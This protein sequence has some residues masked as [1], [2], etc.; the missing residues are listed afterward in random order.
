M[1][2]DSNILHYLASM[3][4]FCSD[5]RDEHL[6]EFSQA[7][8]VRQFSAKEMVYETNAIQEHV[9]F[10]TKGMVRSHYISETGDDITSWFIAENEFVTDYPAFLSRKPSRYAFET[11]EPTTGVFLP[12]SAINEG[13]AKHAPL[14]K[15][16]RLVAE[17][18][19]SVQQERIESFLFKSAKERYLEVL[20]H[21]ADL[22]NRASQRH[23]ASYIGIE[24]QSLTRIRKQLLTE[25]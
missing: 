6:T 22:V 11:L 1:N 25:K 2:L 9:I 7:L 18:I 12:K 21:P 23:L 8:F 20:G 16:G 10:I 3:K 13:Y 4:H 17:F 24:R 5:I 19:L 14:E 15:Y